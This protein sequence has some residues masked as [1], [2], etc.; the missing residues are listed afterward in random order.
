MKPSSL[1]P[2]LLSLLLLWSCG[3]TETSQAQTSDDAT[4]QL[5]NSAD[6]Q[7]QIEGLSAGQLLDVR[8]PEEFGAGTIP[9][10]ANLNVL[11]PSRFSV[12][13]TELDPQAPIYVYCKSGKRSNKAVN[14]M[15]AAGF[16]QIYE[17]DGGFLAWKKDGLPVQE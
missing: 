6:F 1:F 16:Q 10:S 2:L 14:A 5:L 13:L 4:Y 8:T 11:D 17:L 3:S 12:G 7:A 9:G 15:K